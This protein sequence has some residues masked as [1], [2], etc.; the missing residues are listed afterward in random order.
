MPC[1]E[2]GVLAVTPLPKMIDAGEPGGVSCTTRKPS[3]P[4]TSASNRKP[5]DSKSLGAV[6]VSDWQHHNFE[7]E[8]HLAGSFDAHT[9]G[10]P[11]S[12]RVVYKIQTHSVQ[13]S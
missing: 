8:I 7:P 3:S 13:I 4:G 9:V 5:S 12:P 11:R 10:H 2:P 1:V 6:D